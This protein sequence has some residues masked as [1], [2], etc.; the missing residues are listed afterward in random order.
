MKF[1]DR[2]ITRFCY[3]H[4]RFGIPN[5]MLYLVIGS[6]IVYLVGAMD[7][8]GIFYTYLWFDPALI[9][10]GQVWRLVTFLFMPINDGFLFVLLS[11]YFYYFIGSSLE[12][13]WGSGRFT[14][15]Y[16]GG[17]LLYVIFGFVV[18]F[19]VGG[20]ADAELYRAVLP[21]L[22][23]PSHLN[24][25]MFFAFAVLWPDF[26]VLLFFIIPVRMKWLALLDAAFF[27][28]S[29]FSQ[30][31]LFPLNLLPLVAILNFLI[32]CGSDLFGFFKLS[33]GSYSRRVKF[34][35]DVHQAKN[36]EKVRGYRHKC[37]VCGRTD[38]TNPEL[39][40]RYCSRCEGYHCFC[41]DHINNHVHFTK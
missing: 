26:Q 37:A 28:Y 24:L 32:F 3:K 40:F 31:S 7:T 39:E 27:I 38:V 34:R 6:G 33:N 29:I 14:I 30:M 1:I 35:A 15:Y 25:S 23:T 8:T 18:Y 16:I 11:L 12:R 5:L 36:E 21:M 13:Q 17:V 9:L 4:P 19:A 22:M 20:R 10:R 2:A 41:E